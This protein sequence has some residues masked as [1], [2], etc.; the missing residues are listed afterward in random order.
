MNFVCSSISPYKGLKLEDIKPTYYNRY[1]FVCEQNDNLFSLDSFTL[2]NKFKACSGD[3]IYVYGM[4]RSILIANPAHSSWMQLEALL[5]KIPS[6]SINGH[7]RERQKG[8]IEI[9]LH[10]RPCLFPGKWFP[11]NHFPNFHVFVC[12]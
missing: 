4:H 11:G 5:E 9:S 6:T 8:L 12:H 7:L 1:S 10:F 3:D 2:T